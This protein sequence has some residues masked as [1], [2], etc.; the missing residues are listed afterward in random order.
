MSDTIKPNYLSHK[1]FMFCEA[2]IKTNNASEAARQ[3]GYSVKTAG[4]TGCNLLK[5]PKIKRYLEERTRPYREQ[6]EAEERQAV[7][8]SNEILE[9]LTATMRGELKSVNGFGAQ[10]D[11]SLRERTTAA[12]ELAKRIVDNEQIDN[13]VKI[14]VDIPRPAQKEEVLDN[15]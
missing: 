6:Q 9:Y 5:H 11:A 4:V 10:V 13:P 1:Y 2:Y 15:E 12:I 3:A 8:D 7:A 14:I